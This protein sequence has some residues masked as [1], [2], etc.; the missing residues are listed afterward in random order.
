VWKLRSGREPRGVIDH[1]DGDNGNDRFRNLRD[2]S[3]R[4]NVVNQRMRRDNTSGF[5]GVSKHR[6]RWRAAIQHGG[7]TIYL[8]KYDTPEQAAGVYDDASLIYQTTRWFP[9]GGVYD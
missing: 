9:F 6:R 1:F 7:R 2:I 3:Q 5:R 8:G 4:H